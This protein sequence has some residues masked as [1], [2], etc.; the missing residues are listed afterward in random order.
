MTAL[1]TCPEDLIA[2]SRRGELPEEEQRA[3]RGVLGRSQ[4]AR[5]LHEVGLGFDAESPVLPGDE[6]FLARLAERVGPIPSR[7]TRG[8]WWKIA[9]P[10]AAAGC[11][12]AATAAAS[13]WILLRPEPPAATAAG[14][15][16]EGA[17]STTPPKRE[18]VQTLPRPSAGPSTAAPGVSSN[19]PRSLGAPGAA[20]GP[21]R[22]RDSLSPTE[23]AGREAPPLESPDLLFARA[24][25]ARR[26]GRTAEAMALY[27]R[28]GSEHAATPEAQQAEL[29]L[30]E[31]HL[32]RGAPSAALAHFRRYRGQ[33]LRAEALWGQARALRQL[34]DVEQEREVLL[35]LCA[36]LPTSPYAEPARK[37]LAMVAE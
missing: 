3:L 13:G 9:L 32:Q 7:R 36:E 31:L 10:A 23:S 28:L 17:S 24:N 12:V 22:P 1:H 2:R 6:E 35:M 26:A 4:E 37:R 25:G 8:P 11:L 14:S 29:S 19:T 15:A 5:V 21:D 34:G 33:S 30:G 20:R 18:P 16:P 27:Q